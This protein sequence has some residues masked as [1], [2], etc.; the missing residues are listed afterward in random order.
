MLD[1]LPICLV[2]YIYEFVGLN[3]EHFQEHVIPQM[4]D[5]VRKRTMRRT[6]QHLASM[7]MDR[8]NLAFDELIAV[9]FNLMKYDPDFHHV[10]KIFFNYGI[11][12]RLWKETLQGDISFV[13]HH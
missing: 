6:H 5:Y 9:N 11:M 13:V 8:I 1:Q 3:R 4:N 12:K 2:D 10:D 7:D